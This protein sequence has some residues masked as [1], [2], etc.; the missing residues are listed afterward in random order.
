MSLAPKHPLAPDAALQQ[1]IALINAGTY[2]AAAAHLAQ[3]LEQFPEHKKL[4]RVIF[5]AGL[6]LAR[7]KQWEQAAAHFKRVTASFPDSEFADQALYEWAW[8]ERAANKNADAIKLY[9]QLLTGHPK[10]SLVVKVQSELAELNLDAGAQDK[11]IA[12][13]TAT[14]E[15]VKDP[16]LL[17]EIR[18]HLASAHFKKADHKNAAVQ[19][20][21]LLEDY[22]KSKLLASMHFQ[23]GESQF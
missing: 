1:G 22:P 4:G 16:A 3:V 21:Q 15:T 13:L 8:C 6:A 19:F 18:Y 11:V 7:L 23:A 10:S 9:E 2:E 20:E 17:E 14:M 5:H 12:Q